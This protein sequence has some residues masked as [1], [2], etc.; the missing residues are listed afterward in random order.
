MFDT[1]AQSVAGPIL[2]EKRP[3][4]AIRAFHSVLAND[5]TMPGQYPQ[6]FELRYV[7]DQDE[8]T[9]QITATRPET[10]ATGIAWLQATADRVT[11]SPLHAS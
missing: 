9:G 11:D 8:D 10:I 5:K 7:G 1:E 3:A 2:I 4:P 6:H